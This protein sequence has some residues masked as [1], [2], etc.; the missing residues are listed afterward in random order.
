MQPT[1]ACSFGICTRRKFEQD[2]T[3]MLPVL[4]TANWGPEGLTPALWS[5]KPQQ[6]QLLLQIQRTGKT[7]GAGVFLDDTY[8]A[9]DGSM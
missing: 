1:K 5:E 4:A 6:L 8:R 3:P 2:L 9:A 7:P